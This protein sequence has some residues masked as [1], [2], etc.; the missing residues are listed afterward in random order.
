MKW[1]RILNDTP[2]HCLMLTM[3]NRLNWTGENNNTKNIYIVLPK[4]LFF[5]GGGQIIETIMDTTCRII[6]KPTAYAHN[7]HTHHL[8]LHTN[9]YIL[10]H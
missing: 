10:W 5:F 3:S 7:W 6:N 2:P 9:Y 4:H 8:F 1:H